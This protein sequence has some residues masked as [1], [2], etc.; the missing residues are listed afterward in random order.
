MP[1]FSRQQALPFVNATIGRHQCPRSLCLHLLSL[2]MAFKWYLQAMELASAQK[3]GTHFPL[4]L[5]LS[6]NPARELLHIMHAIASNQDGFTNART[7]KRMGWRPRYAAEASPAA[8]SAGSPATPPS[9]ATNT[10]AFS[11]EPVLAPKQTASV[12]GL[13]RSAAAAAHGEGA[14]LPACRTPSHREN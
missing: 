13:Q 3:A 2:C 7:S 1:Q 10:A 4:Y 9:R 6:T 11:K 14:P 8:A 5:N 12:K